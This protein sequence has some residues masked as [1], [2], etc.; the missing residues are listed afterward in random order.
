[1]ALTIKVHTSKKICVPQKSIHSA[2]KIFASQF[3]Q[4]LENNRE[5]DLDIC[6][7][8]GEELLREKVISGMI[9]HFLLTPAPWL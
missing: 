7:A 4:L 5:L 1:M 9:L 2:V 3:V 8:N 6:L